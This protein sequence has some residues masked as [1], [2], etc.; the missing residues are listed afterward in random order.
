MMAFK[1]KLSELGSQ[2]GLSESVSSTESETSV[3]SSE[4]III[5]MSVELSQVAKLVA[6]SSV[7]LSNWFCKFLTPNLETLCQH[8]KRKEFPA[9]FAVAVGRVMSPEKECRCCSAFAN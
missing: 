4:S 5:A 3:F 2:G 9:V 6:I 7:E 8:H 1:S